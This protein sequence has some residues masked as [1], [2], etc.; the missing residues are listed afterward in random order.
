M[1]LYQQM[2]Q[3]GVQRLG[4][5]HHVIAKNSTVAIAVWLCIQLIHRTLLMPLKSHQARGQKILS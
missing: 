1:L 3:Q 2:S 4:Y 5:Q